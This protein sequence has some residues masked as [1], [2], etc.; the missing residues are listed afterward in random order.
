MF[1]L[2]IAGRS[3]VISAAF[4]GGI[5]MVALPGIW[6]MEALDSKVI[7]A[8]GVGTA[9]GNQNEADMMHDALRA[10]VL[11][12]KQSVADGTA[13]PGE[14]YAGIKEHGERFQRLVRENK[15]I[16]LPEGLHK[17]VEDLEP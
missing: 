12:A 4:I 14:I 8:Q 16:E 6:G 17:Q 2:S 3:I 9:F 10:D 1:G 11:L 13:N 15:E 7:Y 5:V